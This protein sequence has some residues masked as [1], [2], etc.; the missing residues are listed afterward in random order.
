LLVDPNA[1]LPDPIAS[2]RLPG[3]TR[4]SSSTSAASSMTSFR[5]A[6]RSMRGSI[7][8]DR[9]PNQRRSVAALPNDLITY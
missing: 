3:G 1:V 6:T 4:R 8:G 5:R 9:C 2:S 7:F